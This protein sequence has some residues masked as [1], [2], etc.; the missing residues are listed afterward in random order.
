MDYGIL[1][2]SYPNQLVYKTVSYASCRHESISNITFEGM[3][4]THTSFSN[5][6][7]AFGFQHG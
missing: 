6:T 2:Y 7:V 4:V 3:V 1:A 5:K